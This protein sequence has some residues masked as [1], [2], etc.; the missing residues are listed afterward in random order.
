MSISGVT[1]TTNPLATYTS[2]FAQAKQDMQALG[3]ALSSGNLTDAQNAFAQ[4]QQN[5]P[6]NSY[7]GPHFQDNSLRWC[8]RSKGAGNERTEAQKLH[9]SVQDKS[10]S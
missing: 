7:S 5:L 10:C 2:P 8:L 1:S 3:T 9:R 6:A 4:L